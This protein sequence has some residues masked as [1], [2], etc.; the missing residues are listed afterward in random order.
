MLSLGKAKGIV[1]THTLKTNAGG[2]SDEFLQPYKARP[3]TTSIAAHRLVAGALGMAPRVP[4]EVRDK[5][6]QKL[7]EAKEKR[8]QEKQQ[9]IDIWDGNFGKCAMDEV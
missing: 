5:E 9:K 6:R 8:R 3:Q 4:R 2:G 1:R 7:K